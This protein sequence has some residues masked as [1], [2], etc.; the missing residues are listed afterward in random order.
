MHIIRSA[1]GYTDAQIL[2]HVREYGIEWLT[3]ATGFINEDTKRDMEQH[4]ELLRWMV[5]V[6]P[7]ARTPMDKKGGRSLDSYSRQLMH[8]LDEA[9]PWIAEKKH[10][11]IRD[12]LKKPPQSTK[13]RTIE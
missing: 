8:A 12:R 7:L 2:E 6:A 5:S 11:A 4:I 13:P 10:Q 3:E 9:L 1:Y